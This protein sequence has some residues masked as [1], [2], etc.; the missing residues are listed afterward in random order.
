MIVPVYV[1]DCHIAGKTCTSVDCIKQQLQSKF[2]L[3]DLGPTNWF[4]GINIQ[5]NHT[6]HLLSLSQCFTKPEQLLNTEETEFMKDKPTSAQWGNSTG[7][8]WALTQTLPLQ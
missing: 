4:L 6:N 3:H 8:P 1:D 2:K 7:L 5:H